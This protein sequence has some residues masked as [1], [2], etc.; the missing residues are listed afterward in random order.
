[1]KKSLPKIYAKY[2]PNSHKIFLV[3]FQKMPKWKPSCPKSL[4]YMTVQLDE[5][6]LQMHRSKDAANVGSNHGKFAANRSVISLKMPTK[7]L[8]L[9]LELP[10]WEG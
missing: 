5:K 7:T 2:S 10:K 6:L 3:L 1:M 4:G 8:D 9:H